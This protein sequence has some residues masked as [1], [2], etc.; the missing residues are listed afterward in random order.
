MEEP[1]RLSSQSSFTKHFICLTRRLSSISQPLTRF[2]PKFNLK[3]WFATLADQIH[4][5]KAVIMLRMCGLLIVAA[6][7]YALFIS[8]IFT[9]GKRVTLGQIYE[10]ESVRLFAQSQINETNIR[11]TLRMV[12]NFPHVAGTEGNYALAQLMEERFKE[13]MMDSVKLERYDVYLNYPTNDGRRVAIIDP[14]NLIWQAKLDEEP[15]YPGRQQSPVFHGHSKSGNVTGPLVYANYGSRE[16]FKRLQEMGIPLNG[17]VILV[18]YYGTQGD[19]ALKVKAA[20]LAGAVG[21]IIYSDP[22]E[23]GFKNG[24]A[25]PDGRYMPADGVQRGAVSLMSWVAGDVLSPGWASTKEDK[26]RLLIEETSGLV[27]IP[28]LPISWRDAQH[29][30]KA[31]NGHGKKVPPDWIGGVPAIEEWWTGDSKSPMVHL[32]NLQDEVQRQPI[33]NVIGQITG[34]EQPDRKIIIGNH[35]DA[36]CYGATD[37][38]SGTA[39][40]LEIVKVIGELRAQGWVP[41]RTIEVASWDGEEYNLI[42][43]TE[44]VEEHVTDLRL[45]GIAY[46][47]VDVAVSG[48]KFHASGSPIFEQVLLQVLKRTADPILNRSLQDLWDES[49]SRLE[50]LGAGSDYVAFQDIAGV[51]SIDLGFSGDAAYPYHSCYDNFDWMSRFGDPGFRYHGVLGQ[52]WVLLLLEL[53]DSAIMPLDLE[54]Y[55]RQVSNSITN[56]ENYANATG[57]PLS[58]TT[59]PTRDS[60]STVNMSPLHEAAQAFKD[61]AAKFGEWRDGWNA[62]FQATGGFETNAMTIK[63][64]DYNMRMTDFETNLLDL[65][66]GGGVRF[67]KSLPNRHSIYTLLCCC[68][69]W[70]C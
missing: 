53:C 37:P 33:Y 69:V 64:Q 10:P 39:V 49:N 15:V 32:M 52:V 60:A 18:R 16:D 36:W 6:F 7:I 19:R 66:D 45:N 47:N 65:G 68:Y 24:P 3:Q 27:K 57:V 38:G 51:S 22:A 11:E 40:L 48:N 21:C 31:L 41:L 5:Q 42:G 13:A 59:K 12:S 25:F 50:G 43:S 54:A 55:A 58:D 17:S 9:F 23:D 26:H 20:E 61:E 8:D 70:M 35:R 14:P 29:L 2:F 63:R 62:T 56:L 34:L 44:H 30:L 28:S 67:P 46:I 1:E 4:G